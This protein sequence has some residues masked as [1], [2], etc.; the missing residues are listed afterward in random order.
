MLAGGMVMRS[1]TLFT[2]IGVALFFSLSAAGAAQ[3]QRLQRH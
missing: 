1:I 3:A 2:V